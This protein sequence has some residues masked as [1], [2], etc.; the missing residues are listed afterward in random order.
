MMRAKNKINMYTYTHY[1]KN[2]RSL[3]TLGILQYE[4]ISKYLSQPIK[5]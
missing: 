1:E 2:I 5:L 4:N 3:M